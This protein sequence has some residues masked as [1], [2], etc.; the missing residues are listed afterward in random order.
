VTREELEALWTGRHVENWPDEIMLLVNEVDKVSPLTTIIE[1]GVRTCGTFRLWEKL[2]PAGEGMIIGVDQIPVEELLKFSGVSPQYRPGM[3][4]PCGTKE[5]H[6]QSSTVPPLRADPQGATFWNRQPSCSV[7]AEECTEDCFNPADSDR[8]VHF[9]IGDST[10]IEV[11]D[12][13]AEI[14]GDRQAD[15]IFHDGGHF[16]DVPLKDFDNIVQPFLRPGGL[17][18][19][20]DVGD[21]VSRKTCDGTLALCNRLSDNQKLPQLEPFVAEKAGIALWRKP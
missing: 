9:A 14:L 17:L 7:F 13:I 19:I 11:H 5:Q 21:Q 3:I 16:G 20:A 4:V 15:F 2:V 18:A 12:K 10:S 6:Q 8:Q 1:I